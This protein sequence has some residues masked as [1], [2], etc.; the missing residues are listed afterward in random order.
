[1]SSTEIEDVPLAEDEVEPDDQPDIEPDEPGIDDE[2][3]EDEDEDPE[4]T[5]LLASAAS[6]K[7]IERRQKSL[8]REGDRHE[9]RVR[10]ILGADSEGLV[11]CEACPAAISGYHYGPD[12]Y[13]PGSPER[14]LYEMLQ[15]GDASMMRHPEWLQTCDEC[16]GFGT[17][18]TGARADL[19]RTLMCP[20][21]K[22]SGYIDTRRDTTAAPIVAENG[23]EPPPA[24]PAASVDDP[25]VDMWG[26]KRA[27]PTGE[28]NPR[29]G[30]F[31][32][33]LTP[34]ERAADEADGIV[35]P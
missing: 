32:I 35:L 22:G 24:A 3:D 1:M 30:K 7:E 29:F 28:V 17:V 19:T 6:D 33:F 23:A 15:A 14:A 26:R 10:E 9:K 5:A 31:P 34:E 18:L 13:P 4:A 25:D 11:K 20:I 21:C 27:L 2:R 8:D 16:N 12:D